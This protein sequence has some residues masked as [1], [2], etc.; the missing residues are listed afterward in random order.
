[1]AIV[2]ELDRRPV[3]A[4]W[5]VGPVVHHGSNRILDGS[6]AHQ[7]GVGLGQPAEQCSGQ[8]RHY[9]PG[10]EDHG[11]GRPVVSGPCTGR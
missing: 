9:K 5:S 7:I 10:N 4:G 6:E 11:S 8:G 2:G 3:C 1:M